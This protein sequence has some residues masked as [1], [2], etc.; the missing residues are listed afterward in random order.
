MEEYKEKTFTKDV[1]N[2]QQEFERET[3][4]YNPLKGLC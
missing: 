1:E 2:G 3:G 4:I